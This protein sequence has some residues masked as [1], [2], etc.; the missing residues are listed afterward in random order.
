MIEPPKPTN[1]PPTLRRWEESAVPE[2]G[3][4]F[5]DLIPNLLADVEGEKTEVPSG[6]GLLPRSQ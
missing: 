2:A 5:P 3:I 4:P 6:V 1:E